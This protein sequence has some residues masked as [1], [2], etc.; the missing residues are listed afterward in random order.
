MQQ[1]SRRESLKKSN[2]KKENVEK[3]EMADL[4]RDIEK[5]KT[6]VMEWLEKRSQEYVWVWQMRKKVNWPIKE[7][8][9]ERRR[10][11]MAAMKREDGKGLDNIKLL[12]K[13]HVK[14]KVKEVLIVE[15]MKE[16]KKEGRV[17]QEE[18]LKRRRNQERMVSMK[19]ALR[20][21]CWSL[22]LFANVV[23]QYVFAGM[24]NLKRK[25]KNKTLKMMR[26]RESKPTVQSFGNENKRRQVAAAS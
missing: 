10:K 22:V 2:K 4:R 3:K 21:T 19:E 18:A 25:V 8:V 16:N 26:E 5:C 17:V 14:E 13:N 7:I 12:C 9:K 23:F 24:R 11:K 20:E 6:M 1:H 15:N